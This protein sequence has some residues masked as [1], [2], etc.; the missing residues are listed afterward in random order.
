VL[1]WS[2]TLVDGPR[3]FDELLPLPPKATDPYHDVVA[4]AV[5]H[6]SADAPPD[7][8]AV[9]NLSAFLDST[10]RLTWRVPAGSFQ[11]LRFVRSNTGQRLECPSPAGQSRFNSNRRV[12]DTTTTT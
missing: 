2:E 4:L 11:I 3:R 9:I 6:T 8:S 5:P 12:L 10:G 7:E 1:L